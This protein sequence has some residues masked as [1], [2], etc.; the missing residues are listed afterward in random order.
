[1]TILG[2]QGLGAGRAPERRSPYPCS[3]W[4]GKVGGPGIALWA[5][6]ASGDFQ[7][8]EG[9]AWRLWRDA[10]VRVLRDRGASAGDGC[11]GTPA[12]AQGT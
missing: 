9:S 1:M 12:R 8:G 7:T 2:E 4:R 6:P 3:C 10:G 5:H 11:L